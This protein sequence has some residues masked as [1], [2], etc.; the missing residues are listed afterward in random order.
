[1]TTIYTFS[2]SD[3]YITPPSKALLVKNDSWYMTFFHFQEV[4]HKITKTKT[5][6]AVGK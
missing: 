6:L 1:M 5:E 2:F 4:R 3:Q